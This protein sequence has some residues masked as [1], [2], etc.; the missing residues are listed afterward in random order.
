[1]GDDD[2]M[3]DETEKSEEHKIL[4]SEHLARLYV[5]ALTWGMGAYL[6]TDDRLKYDLFLK[7]TLSFLD[8]P[9]NNKKNPQVRK[10]IENNFQ[11]S[12]PYIYIFRQPSL[13]MS[14]VLRENGHFGVL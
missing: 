8:L 5:F 3:L 12:K 6:E 1:M 13:I 4:T 7:E 10:K 11:E 2:D 14:L 9:I